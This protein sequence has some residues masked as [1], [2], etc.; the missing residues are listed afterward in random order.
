MCEGRNH[1]C[2]PAVEAR[3]GHA[4]IPDIVCCSHGRHQ[5]VEARPRKSRRRQ[6]WH[7]GHLRCMLLQLLHQHLDH[8]RCQCE[9]GASDPRLSS[10]CW[11]YFG[12]SKSRTLCVTCAKSSGSTGACVT[13]RIST[14]KASRGTLTANSGGCTAPG[15]VRRLTACRPCWPPPPVTALPPQWTS[16]S[17]SRLSSSRRLQGSEGTRSAILIE[18]RPG[19]C[20]TRTDCGRGCGSAL[21]MQNL[22]IVIVLTAASVQA[23]ACRTDIQCWMRCIAPH[24]ACV[25]GGGG[26]GC[27]AYLGGVNQESDH[28][29]QLHAAAAL[30]QRLGC[31]CTPAAQSRPL[32]SPHE[33]HRLQLHACKELP[34]RSFL[35][36]FCQPADMRMLKGEC[37]TGEET[38]SQRPAGGG[39]RRR[40]GAHSA[41]S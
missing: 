2:K 16:R 17:Q 41:S 4:T 37:P 38:H 34:Q 7:P 14:G 12:Y 30:R 36:R 33:R 1:P 5:V 20:S 21:P 13:C 25:G 24:P 6:N 9:T 28:L 40:R 3:G 26:Q 39:G 15:G 32:P 10:M 18:E 19:Q 31:H 27:R 23:A 8:L 22:Q 35:A 11:K 29:R